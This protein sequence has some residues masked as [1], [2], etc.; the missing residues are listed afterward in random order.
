M[1]ETLKGL[2]ETAK[3]TTYE[4]LALL[5]PGGVILAVLERTHGATIPSGTIGSIAA[6]Y[7]FGTVLQA[8]GDFILKRKKI[9]GWLERD[10]SDWRLTEAYAL[11]MVAKRLP[12]VPKG[13]M[14]DICLTQLGARRTIYDKFIALRDTARGLAFATVVTA[15]LVIVD[16]WDMLTTGATWCVIVKIGGAIALGTMLFLAFLQRYARFHPLA[17]QVVYGQFLATQLDAKDSGPPE[18]ESNP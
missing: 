10:K 1:L 15:V 13:A 17:H 6:A 9:A 11:G 7:A 14:L 2:I 16:E 3:A 12:A 18:K 8:I 4:L 5:L